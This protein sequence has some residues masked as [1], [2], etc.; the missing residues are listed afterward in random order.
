MQFRVALLNH[1]KGMNRW[2]ERRELVVEQLGDLRPDILALNEIDIELESARWLQRTAWERLGLSYT[3]LQQS[4]VNSLSE[5]GGQALLIRFPVIESANLDYRSRDRVAQVARI[6]IGGTP[7]DVYLTHLQAGEGEEMVRQ[8][9]VQRLLRWIGSRDDVEAR[10]VCGDFNAVPDSPSI[11]E[12][13]SRFQNV[14][15][16][17]T[18]STLLTPPEERPPG[19]E[20]LTRCIDYIWVDGPL[21]VRDSGVCFDRPGQNDPSLWPSD[22]LGVWADLELPGA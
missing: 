16:R 4:Q 2:L 10:I 6:D 11:R 19:W 14:Q 15:S 12:M 22:H 17:P 9:Q 5:I 20:P 13:A 8:L 3:L 21:D 1:Q 7:T 18:A